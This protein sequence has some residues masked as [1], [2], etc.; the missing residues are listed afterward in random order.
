MEIKF[1]IFKKKTPRLS[2]KCYSS[3]S[4]REE[5]SNKEEK[6]EWKKSLIN[7]NRKDYELKKLIIHVIAQ[8]TR[9]RLV[10]WR[11]KGSKRGRRRNE[12]LV[13]LACAMKAQAL[14]TLD[15]R[16]LSLVLAQLTIA[17]LNLVH[18]ELRRQW[19]PTCSSS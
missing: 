2:I 4:N 13:Y 18:L 19:F 11:T 14:G 10:E 12:A 1:L 16:S 6:K 7:T 17:T 9:S 3:N 5:I 15:P 8:T